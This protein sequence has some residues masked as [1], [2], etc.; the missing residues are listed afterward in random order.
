MILKVLAEFIKYN[1]MVLRSKRVS[2]IIQY[3]L[4]LKGNRVSASEKKKDPYRA[5]TKRSSK[6]S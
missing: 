6:Q 5:I 2:Y 3:K 4:K 1:Y